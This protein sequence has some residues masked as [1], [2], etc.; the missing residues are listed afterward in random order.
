M[1]SG[2]DGFSCKGGRA[3]MKVYLNGGTTHLFPYCRGTFGT[4]VEVPDPVG[5][6]CRICIKRQNRLT[7]GEQLFKLR[8]ETGVSY[9][10][11]ARGL[12]VSRQCVRQL[13]ENYK[14]AL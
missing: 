10:R 6:I 11:I 14:E 8:Q 13:V 12:K 3:G 4:A 2:M 1:V 9:A 5:R 7:R